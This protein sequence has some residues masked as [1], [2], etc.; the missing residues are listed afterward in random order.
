MPPPVRSSSSVRRLN[1]TLDPDAIRV[2]RIRVLRKKRGGVLSSITAKRKEI[3]DL[4][5]DVNNLEA[6]KVKLAE[7][8]DLFRKFVESQNAYH[9]ELVHEAQKE[10]SNAYFSEIESSL[11]FFCHTVNDWLRV[12]EV[13]L[14]E[15]AITPDDSASQVIPNEQHK[16]K[17]SCGSILSRACKASPI[18]SAR[19][20]EA[21]K[22]AGIQAE[23]L[24]LKQRQRLHET[25]MNP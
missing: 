22:I 16:H 20:E 2:E 5:N 15:M 24:A 12:T 6:V 25:E 8:T 9:R 3:D 4:L 17:S 21:A 23:A 11:R 13:K 14:H 10:Q 18:S 19:A 1:V 7:I